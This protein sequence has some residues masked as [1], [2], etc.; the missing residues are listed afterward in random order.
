MV[1]DGCNNAER[2]KILDLYDQDLDAETI[3]R[4]MG[5]TIRIVE[6]MIEYYR[7]GGKERRQEEKE[8]KA[9]AEAAGEEYT[10]PKPKKAKKA[11][12]KGKKTAEEDFK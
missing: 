8:A 6:N 9:A 5:L 1:K 4:G 7:K 2:N 10:P 3:A 12:A 11:K